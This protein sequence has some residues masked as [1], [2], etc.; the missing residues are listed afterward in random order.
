[1]TFGLRYPISSRASQ[2]IIVFKV[3]SQTSFSISLIGNRACEC[4]YSLLNNREEGGDRRTRHT[5]RFIALSCFA[6]LS[7]ILFIIIASSSLHS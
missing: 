4:D 3:L 2:K 1:M 6:F 5:E 7:G